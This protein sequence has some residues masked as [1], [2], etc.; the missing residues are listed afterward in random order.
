ML[1]EMSAFAGLERTYTIS[2]T[3]GSGQIIPHLKYATKKTLKNSLT[4]FESMF[5]SK[6]DCA[7]NQ[8]Q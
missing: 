6:D 7:G 1:C 5:N 2:H 4:I 8:A 3:P